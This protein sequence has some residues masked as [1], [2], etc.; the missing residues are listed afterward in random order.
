MD[1]LTQAGSELRIRANP[2]SGTYT[3]SIFGH[4]RT[5]DTIEQAIEWACSVRDRGGRDDISIR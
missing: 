1:I 4:V 2:E 3:A 5:F